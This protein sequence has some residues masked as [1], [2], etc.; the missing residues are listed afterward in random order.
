MTLTLLPEVRAIL[1]AELTFDEVWVDAGGGAELSPL[2]PEEE[3]LVARAVEKRKRE[4]RAGR[5][6]ARRA[7]TQAG[8]TP[9]AL[10]R[11]PHG[12]PRFPAGFRG[13]ITHTGRTSTYAAAVITHAPLLVGLDA[14]MQDE[15]APELARRVATPAEL[16]LARTIA[17]EPGLLVFAA[18]E[19]AYKCVH[20]LCGRVLG[21]QEV[22][23]A[24][25]N[26]GRLD[27]SVL[28]LPSEPVVEVRWLRLRGV[29]LC[30]ALLPAP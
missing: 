8:G 24:Q 21:F 20:A 27:L 17:D 10:L 19:A 23:L 13:S 4:F 25:A 2:F 5:H 22:R 9:S 7:L 12:E 18:K 29:T 6:V 16:E 15:L 1:P 28:A 30:L 26:R 14:E 11:G 3:L